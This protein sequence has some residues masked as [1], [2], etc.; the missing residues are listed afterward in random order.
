MLTSEQ[1]IKESHVCNTAD[2]LYECRE[3]SRLRRC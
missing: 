2:R 1:A 3:V